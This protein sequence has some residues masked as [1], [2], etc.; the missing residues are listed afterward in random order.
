MTVLRVLI[1]LWAGCAVIACPPDAE[2]AGG[3]ACPLRI[4]VDAEYA[5]P[6]DVKPRLSS[7]DGRA[8]V[9]L[10]GEIGDAARV[11]RASLPD[12][13]SWA[14]MPFERRVPWTE[15]DLDDGVPFTAWKSVLEPERE[16]GS[17]IRAG[18]YRYVLIYALKHPWRANAEVC[19]LRSA[20][21]TVRKD[22]FWML[23]DELSAAGDRPPDLRGVRAMLPNWLSGLDCRGRRRD[24]R[25][26]LAGVVLGRFG[27][28]EL[29]KRSPLQVGEHAAQ[30]GVEPVGLLLREAAVEEVRHLP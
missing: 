7:T 22:S 30:M 2:A 10:A 5:S 29:L 8:A 20:T 28:S 4:E 11:E 17:V 14:P 18:M 15:P 27:P 1:T 6:D 16:G 19:V 13:G 21:F 25:T 9:Y 24:S 3:A 23:L 12:I 26:L